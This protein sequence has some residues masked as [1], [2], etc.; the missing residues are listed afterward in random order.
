[1]ESARDKMHEGRNISPQKKG[2]NEKIQKY[3]DAHGRDMIELNALVVVNEFDLRDIIRA[4]LKEHIDA[5]IW[6]ERKEAMREP[7]KRINE[8][9]E[10]LEA[11]LDED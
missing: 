3:I 1:M 2:Q 8:L 4:A 9:V 11:E 7:T 5:D 10:Q 6:N